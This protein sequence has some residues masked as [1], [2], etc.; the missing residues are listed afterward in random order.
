[1]PSNVPPAKEQHER[2]KQNK[3][4]ESHKEIRELGAK[5]ATEYQTKMTFSALILEELIPPIFVRNLLEITKRS[6]D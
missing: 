4:D 6:F 1:M 3:D 5:S 2:K